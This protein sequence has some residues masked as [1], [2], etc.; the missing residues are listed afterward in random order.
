M[1]R[2]RCNGIDIRKESVMRHKRFRQ[3]A[4]NSRALP[5]PED[6]EIGQLLERKPITLDTIGT[7]SLQDGW[8]MQA[9]VHGNSVPCGKGRS[10]RSRSQTRAVAGM[11]SS[12]GA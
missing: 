8:I 3:H 5:V 6:S 2:R 10:V 7:A 1:I 11:F 4:F 9:S 12:V